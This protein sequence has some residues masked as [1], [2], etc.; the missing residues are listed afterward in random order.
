MGPLNKQQKPI[1]AICEFDAQIENNLN[2]TSTSQVP[3]YRHPPPHFAEGKSIV[4]CRHH[5]CH[6]VDQIIVI[7]IVNF[8]IIVTST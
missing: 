8:Q 4:N 6:C 2:S 7:V 5:Q 3:Q 1:A